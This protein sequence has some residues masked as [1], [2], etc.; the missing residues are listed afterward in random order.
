[1]NFFEQI[2]L[3]FQFIVNNKLRATLTVIIIALGITALVGILTAIDGMESSISNSFTN[4]GANS[5][6]L[7]NKEMVVHMGGNGRK[8]R[9]FRPIS[10]DEATKFKTQFEFPSQ[11]TLS[12]RLSQIA[13]LEFQ[14]KKT[15][16][17]IGLMGIDENYFKV[18]GYDIQFGR[19]FSKNEIDEGASVIVLGR[20]VATRLFKKPKNA[21][22]EIISVGHIQYRVVGV[23]ASKG[24]SRFVSSDNNGFLP[25]LN[26]KRS[27]PIPTKTSYVVTI[28][29]SKYQL[30]NPAVSEAENQFRIIRRTPLGIENDFQVMRSDDLAHELINNLKYVT[31]ACVFIAIITLIGAAIGLMNIMLVSVNERTREI[32]ISK[33]IGATNKI[34]LQQFLLES[35]LV[36]QIGGILG[37]IV[38]LAIGNAVSAMMG[39]SFFIPWMWMV[40]GL[41]ICFVV[42]IAAGI[43]PALTASKLNPINALRTE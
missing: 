24:V 15:N 35:V 29:V 40:L 20:D 25:I 38:G 37:V 34:I 17:N 8:P 12:V 33:A 43:Y 9:E 28:G 1:M 36:C 39:S 32:G 7:R 2:K 10:F 13:T 19:N 16:P 3:A 11:V 42:G 26:G 4:M 21:I 23:L 41:V 5:F 6:S 30:L 31:W 22:D 14:S 18:S 27:W